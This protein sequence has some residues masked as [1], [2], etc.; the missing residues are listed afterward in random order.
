MKVLLLFLLFFSVNIVIPQVQHTQI[1]NSSIENGENV[2][3]PKVIVYGNPL[4]KGILDYPGSIPGTSNFWDYQTN[5][6]SLNSI[7]VFGDTVIVCYPT[8]DSTDPTG[9]TTRLA[10][11]LVSYDHGS[12]WGEPLPLSALPDRSGYPELQPFLDGG[13][14]NVAISG[15]KY[16]SSGARGGIWVEA[17]LGFGSFTSNYVPEPGRDFF[18]SYLSGVT[19]AGLFSSV[20]TD[21]PSADSLFFGKYNK[22]T[23]SFSD[24]TIMAVSP[25]NINGSVRY[26]FTA[27]ATGQNLLAVWYDNTKGA[28][29]LRYNKSSDGGNTWGSVGSFQTAFGYAGVVN[30]DTCSPWFGIDAAFK[31]NSTSYGVVWSTLFPTSTGQYSGDPQGCKILFTSPEINGGFPVEVAGRTNMIEISDTN[32]F[33][34]KNLHKFQAGVTPVSHPS[35]AYSSDGSRIVCAFS[36]YTPYDTLDKYL[37]NDIYVTYSDNGGANWATPQKLT[38]TPDWDELY[39]TLSETGNTP[40]SF[41]VKF[42]A[43]RGPGSQSFND[44]APTYRVYHSFKTFNPQSVGITPISSNVPAKYSLQQNYPNPFNPTTVIRYS[45]PKSGMVK[46]AVYDLL[47]KEIAVLGNEYQ[48]AGTYSATFTSGD[49][50]LSSGIYFY[51]L[52]AGNYS[53]TKKMVLVK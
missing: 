27:D 47:G 6:S 43:T 25:I 14:R 22:N 4:V 31:P 20:I 11:Y 33:Y 34:E 48:N 30:G 12:T 36:C 24:K 15:R 35:I 39:P 40:T 37:F 29:A 3:V 2:K 53:E 16:S 28:Y 18:G 45:I 1:L 21:D 9:A 51:K 10:F 44:K 38:N 41:N 8:V 50:H 5:G 26:R 19:F 7:V 46:L 42:Q 32:S 23:N 17:F 13:V 52:T 49:Y